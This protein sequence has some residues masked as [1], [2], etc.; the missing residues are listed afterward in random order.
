MSQMYKSQVGHKVLPII[1]DILILIFPIFINYLNQQSKQ[2]TYTKRL[3]GKQLNNRDIMSAILQTTGPVATHFT[4]LTASPNFILGSTYITKEQFVAAA[5][6]LQ[7]LNLGSLVTVRHIH[8]RPSMNFV[9]KPPDEIKEQLELE[10]NADLCS[11]SLYEE[12]FK[13][14]T[15]ACVPQ[16]TRDKLI[17]LGLVSKE[18]FK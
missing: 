4:V 9:K 1:R 12:K 15:P 18:D 7:D 10:A 6:A 2:R 3:M 16:G 17:S 8:G 14:A 5:S 13:A 11:P